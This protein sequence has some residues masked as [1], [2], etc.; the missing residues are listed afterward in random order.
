MFRIEMNIPEMFFRLFS[1]NI[2]SVES[3]FL[4]HIDEFNH[5]LNCLPSRANIQMLVIYLKL[6]TVKHSLNNVFY[7]LLLH[8]MAQFC[9]RFLFQSRKVHLNYVN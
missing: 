6:S 9:Y 1:G 4:F 8:R 7:F 5:Q 2:L 3:K